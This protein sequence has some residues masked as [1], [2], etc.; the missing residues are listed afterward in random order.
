MCAH[1]CLQRTVH[2]TAIVT[3]PRG[4]PCLEPDGGLLIDLEIEL[5]VLNTFLNLIEPIPLLPH[6]PY[7][8]QKLPP[9]PAPGIL[10][11]LCNDTSFTDL[12]EP[13]QDLVELPLF[14]CCPGCSYF[15]CTVLFGTDHSPS[16]QLLVLVSPREYK[17]QRQ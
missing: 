9:R 12:L 6:W 17:V 15:L 1:R 16:N 7:P 2:S 5:K 14:L 4:T 13:S 3:F 8:F 10:V 11:F